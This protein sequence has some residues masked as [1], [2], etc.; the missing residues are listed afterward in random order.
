MPVGEKTEGKEMAGLAK[1]PPIAGPMI[2]PIDQTNGI[3]ANAR[4]VVCEQYQVR[5]RRERLTFMLGLLDQLAD[6]GL[7]DS[8]VSICPQRQSMTIRLAVPSTL[9]QESTQSSTSEGHPEVG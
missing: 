8:D 5:S 1:V 3:T 6:H 4:A 2:V 7:D 9:T